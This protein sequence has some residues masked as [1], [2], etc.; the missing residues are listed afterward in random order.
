MPKKERTEA[1]RKAWGE[2]MKQA[3]LAKKIEREQQKNETYTDSK[4]ADADL[5]GDT[6]E[7]AKET[8][9]QEDY[10]SLLAKI[11]ELK[12]NSF[13]DK[14]LEIMKTMQGGAQLTN[15]G[16]VGTVEKYS[17][18]PKNYP[19]PRDRLAE[20]P[21]LQRFAFKHNYQL[22]WEIQISS[23]QTQD[24]INTKEPKFNLTLIRMVLDEET[25]EPVV[26]PS[27]NLKVFD[28]CRLIFH[29]DPQAALAI[30]RE[31]GLEV[32]EETEKTFLDEMRYLRMRDWLLEAFI[33]PKRT[34]VAQKTQ[35]VIGNKLVEVYEISSEN[36][37]KIPWGD[38]KKAKL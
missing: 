30:A 15:R 6:Q 26:A 23:Y 14:M 29:E 4:T 1:E 28:V 34:D 37:A 35:T 7:P 18:D 32:P 33:P 8:I 13:E 38:M 36:S 11:E 31:N 2:K 21:K 24:G 27:G 9:S 20:E 25:G 17:V 19:D 16:V 12:S 3:K 10:Q 22:G 5:P